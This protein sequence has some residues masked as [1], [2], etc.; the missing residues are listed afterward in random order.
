MATNIAT[1]TQNSL[2]TDLVSKLVSGIAESRATTVVAGGGKPLLRMLKSGD[3]VFGAGN[4]EVQDGSHW[5]INVMSLGHGFTCWV[6][7]AGSAKNELRGEV[8]VF[9]PMAVR[10]I[11]RGG[12][13]E[14]AHG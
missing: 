14:S 3:W 5:V 11:S 7:G 9:E 8:M 6:E 12:A 1:K 13:L 4:E 2:S 10:E